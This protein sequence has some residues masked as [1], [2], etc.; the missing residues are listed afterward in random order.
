MNPGPSSLTDSLKVVFS[1]FSSIIDQKNEKELFWNHFSKQNRP[2][3]VSP[4]LTSVFF[5][6]LNIGV[7]FSL[8]VNIKISLC[9]IRSQIFAEKN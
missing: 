3:L 8:A 9:V 4:I 5:L 6:F 7:I 1:T 2:L